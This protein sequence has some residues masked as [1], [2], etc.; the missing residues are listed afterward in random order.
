MQRPVSHAEG[1]AAAA[2][3]PHHLATEA[4]LQIMGVGGNAVDGAIAAN[5]VL[6]A[7]CPDMC[8]MGGD[9]F[10]IVHQPGDDEPA[11]LNASGRGGSG[12]D[13][14]D[15]RG[16]GHVRIPPFSPWAVTAPGC[17][18]GW[19][20]LNRRFSS[21]DLAAVLAPAI[22]LAT[23]GFPTSLELSGALTRG[24]EMLGGVRSA[25][26]L[27][28]RG[29]PPA[30]GTLLRRTDL[31]DT[32]LLLATGGRQAFYEGAPG[33]AIS[34]AT[35][36]LVTKDDLARDHAE[37]VEPLGLDI[38]GSRGWT[39]PPNS[40]GYVTLA[41]LWMVDALGPS[42]D[43]A[44]PAF[45]HALIESYRS[46]S[47]DRDDLVADPDFAP[48]AAQ[49]L[50][51]ITRLGPRLDRISDRSVASWPEHPSVDGD[52]AYLCTRDADGMAVSLIQSNFM[53]IGSGIGAG[54]TGILLHNRGADFTL[55]R[56]HPNQAAPGKR[57]QHTLSPTLWTD[58]GRLSMLLGTRG[59]HQQPQYL[60]QAAAAILVAGLTPTEAQRVPRWHMAPDHVA[61]S[62]M[63]AIE[64]SA[65]PDIVAGLRRRGHVVQVQQ[66]QMEGW[67][68][69]SVM[70]VDE[71]GYVAAAADPRVSTAAAGTG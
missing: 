18:D 55:A 28:P 10:A 17:V 54:G 11:V 63:V 33:E 8:G 31:A 47:W 41:T 40:Q 50:V 52:T 27:Y 34:S 51:S 22:A 38:L 12:L 57:P 53:G 7:V 9:L 69:V 3:S 5:A 62:S 21:L 20:A 46:A 16:R 19:A 2:V 48:I 1:H 26:N 64:S 45:H 37:W 43:P 36:G 15:I 49:D 4:A 14:A 58:D 68:P 65:E 42:A 59:G 56:G 23:N 32:M 70:T 6:G 39:V 35:G 30:P 71:E 60:A 67:G 44:D 29:R 25:A 13:A 66:P 24:A 61:R